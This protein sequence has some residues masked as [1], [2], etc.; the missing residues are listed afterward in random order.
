VGSRDDRGDGRRADGLVQQQLE[1]GPARL[2]VLTVR[3]HEPGPRPIKA[4]CPPDI[5]RD[6]LRSVGAAFQYIQ[7]A[8]ECRGILPMALLQLGNEL[9]GGPRRDAGP[10]LLAEV[11]EVSPPAPVPGAR[12]R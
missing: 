7:H 2:L 4:E 11:T 8:E 1:A 9:E 5:P 10:A 6:V 3:I 12:A